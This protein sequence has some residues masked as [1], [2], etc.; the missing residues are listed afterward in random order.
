MHRMIMDK[1]GHDSEF[2]LWDEA[3]QEVVPSFKY[4]PQV[5]KAKPFTATR[6]RIR[7]RYISPPAQGPTG[8][9]GRTG[10]W[11]DLYTP[12]VDVM[13]SGQPVKLFRDG[14]AVE[15]NTSPVTCRAY[16]WNDTKMA[17]LWG[18][19]AR[20]P[21]H[22]KFTSRPWVEVSKKLMDSFPPDLQVLGC[23]PSLD[24]YTE[25]Q[26]SIA[27]DPMKTF[28]RTCGSHLHMSFVDGPPPEE[29][30]APFIKLADLLIGVP[31]TYVFG[32]ELER[33]R[34]KL[35]GQAGEFRFQ[36]YGGLEYRALSSRLWNHQGVF[37]LF[38]G[39]WKYILGGGGFK[40]LVEGWDK[41]WEPEIQQ[42]INE[43]DIPL[44]EKLLPLYY[45]L[46]QRVNF[47]YTV[48]K[49]AVDEG[50]WATLRKLNLEGAFPD[51]GVWARPFAPEGHSG[52]NDFYAY[53]KQG[54]AYPD[55]D[56]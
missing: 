48:G 11:A 51:A 39:I 8:Y 14:L 30:W 1:V 22:Y 44:C 2:F 43:V 16:L 3:K 40:T 12:R 37:S 6:R 33:K 35:Y 15:I 17:L 56:Y 29:Y 46:I 38:T 7:K 50:L 31:F 42:A 55:G 53:W 32:D 9:I 26:K 49:D 10:R 54:R 34:R 25:R 13:C 41:S 4:Y 45:K 5:E 47:H 18:E 24:A 27:V 23:S 20:M 19:P 52:F 21:K 28:F 36:K